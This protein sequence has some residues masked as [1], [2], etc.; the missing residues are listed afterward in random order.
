MF[1]SSTVVFYFKNGVVFIVFGFGGDGG[2][3]TCEDSNSNKVNGDVTKAHLKPP[4]KAQILGGLVCI[5]IVISDP[6]SEDFTI[7]TQR[8]KG[9]AFFTNLFN[10]SVIAANEFGLFL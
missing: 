7:A 9:S 4:P 8:Q 2:A 5:S 6:Y 1:V 10:A 3:N